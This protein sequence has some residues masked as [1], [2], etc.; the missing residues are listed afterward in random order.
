ML[1]AIAFSVLMDAL[2]IVVL[3]CYY[4]C[5]RIAFVIL[6]EYNANDNKMISN[7]NNKRKKKRLKETEKR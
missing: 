4:Y 3:F 6:S 2:L 5:Y 7:S 1:D